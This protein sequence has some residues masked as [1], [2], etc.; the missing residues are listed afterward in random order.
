MRYVCC[1][2][3]GLCL[4]LVGCVFAGIQVSCRFVLVGSNGVWLGV[5][6]A[7]GWVILAIIVLLA[8][9]FCGWL[10]IT[11]F[12]ATVCAGGVWVWVV[13]SICACC[14]ICFWLCV[15]VVCLPVF[16]CLVWVVLWCDM[17]VALLR[18][19]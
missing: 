2:F 8:R 6:V 5:L 7:F 9:R 3:S 16:G 14:D 10:W 12:L 19:S 17:L 18:I 13:S 1:G 15:S 4:L 11:L